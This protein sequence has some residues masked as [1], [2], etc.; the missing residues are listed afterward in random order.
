MT[1]DNDAPRS[2]ESDV[3]YGYGYGYGARSSFP[4]GSRNARLEKNETRRDAFRFVSND[5]PAREPEPPT[6]PTVP[7]VRMHLPVPTSLVR[8]VVGRGGANIQRVRAESGAK[9]KLH[10]CAPGAATRILELGGARRDVQA[11]RALVVQCLERVF[12]ENPE[13]DEF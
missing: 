10:D 7:T 5:T 11:A 4:A 3:G 8:A 2:C 6:V 12:Q 13:Q 1:N 9:V